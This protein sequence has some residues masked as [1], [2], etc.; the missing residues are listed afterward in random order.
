MN[1][2]F[3]LRSLP[4]IDQDPFADCDELEGAED[5]ELAGLISRVQLQDAC[6]APELIDGEDLIPIFS[7]MTDESWEERFFT[8]LCPSPKRLNKEDDDSEHDAEDDS[9]VGEEEES[10]KQTLKVKSYSDAVESLEDVLKFLE[11]K[12]HTDEATSLS[13][14]SFISAVIDKSYIASAATKQSLITEYF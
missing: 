5:S 4:L 2:D 8:D 13:T 3:E 9:D 11:N 7:E 6:S 14:S 1:E 12:G 10:V